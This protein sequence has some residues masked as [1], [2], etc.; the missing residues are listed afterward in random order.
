MLVEVAERLGPSL[1]WWFTRPYALL[2]WA[3]CHLQELDRRRGWLNRLHRIDL[4]ELM[5]LALLDPQQLPAERR[6][7]MAAAASAES[8]EAARARGLRMIADIRAGQ[9]LS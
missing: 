8:D 6:M 9:V 4:V 1:E 7:H 2:L 5:N 3:Y